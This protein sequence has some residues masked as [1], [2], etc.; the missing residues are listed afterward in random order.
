MLEHVAVPVQATALLA[1]LLRFLVYRSA[2][3]AQIFS[4]KPR[5]V[6]FA[7]R[8]VLYLLLYRRSFLLGV[9]PLSGS[10]P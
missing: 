7:R 3:C 9:G 2:G 6:P 10:F 4:A 5:I 8:R 1:L